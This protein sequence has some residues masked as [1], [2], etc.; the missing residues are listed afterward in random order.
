MYYRA[1][2]NTKFLGELLNR[3]EYPIFFET[4]QPLNQLAQQMTAQPTPEGA[5]RTDKM[6]LTQEALGQELNR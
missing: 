2:K 5:V 1:T 3:S 4:P 6:K